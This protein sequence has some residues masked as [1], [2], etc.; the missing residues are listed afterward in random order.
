MPPL[1]PEIAA[2]AAAAEDTLR[3]VPGGGVRDGG[4]GRFRFIE[5]KG[6]AGNPRP[7]ARALPGVAG[8]PGR[9]PHTARPDCD[10]EGLS[11]G[12]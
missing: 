9:V 8:F 11:R 5:V 4:A 7:V 6:R 3:T 1:T 10:R 2:A 12:L